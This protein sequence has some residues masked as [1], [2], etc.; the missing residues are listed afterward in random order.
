M[1]HARHKR[2]LFAWKEFLSEDSPSNAKGRKRMGADHDTWK[3][4]EKHLNEFEHFKIKG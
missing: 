4:F 1:T 3:A 2:L